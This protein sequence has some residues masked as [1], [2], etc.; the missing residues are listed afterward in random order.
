MTGSPRTPIL[1]AVLLAASACG[2]GDAGPAWA[3]IED[4]LESGVVRVVNVPP[5]AGDEPEWVVEEELRIGAV[6][7]E[8]PTS[9]GQVKGIAVTGDRDVAVL[10]ALAQE[11][12]LFGPGGAHLAT[13]GS[14]GAGPGE[15]EGPWGLMRSADDR[16]WV[17]DHTNDRMS[18]FH[19]A[20][21]FETSYRVH[22]YMYGWVWE[23]A[24]LDDG[25]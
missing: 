8:G 18:V 2:R 24:M 1:V 9:F 12:R 4:T 21:G 22:F 16:L 3:V 11:V 6:D 14:K 20:R 7:A 25:R 23:G 13:Y 5:E 19:P 15:M 17:P 10:D